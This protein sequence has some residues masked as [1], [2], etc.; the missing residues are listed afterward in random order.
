[1]RRHFTLFS[2]LAH[3]VVIAAALFGQQLD[4]GALP[5]PHKLLT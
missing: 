5:T 1:M 2:V 3:A 4:V